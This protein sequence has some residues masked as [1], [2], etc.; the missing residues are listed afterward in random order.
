MEML[1]L[2]FIDK[3]QLSVFCISVI[4]FMLHICFSVSSMPAKWHELARRGEYVSREVVG[5]ACRHDA[6]LIGIE[7]LI[8]FMFY[9][10]MRHS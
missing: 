8:L 7:A 3:F 9:I 4:A 2:D 6:Y 10:G 5:H 1:L